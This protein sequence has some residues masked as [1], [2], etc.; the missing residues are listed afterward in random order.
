MQNHTKELNGKV[1]GVALLR[2]RGQCQV[3]D[4]LR[5]H[6]VAQRDYWMAT[7]FAELPLMALEMVDSF[8]L[9]F[10]MAVRAHSRQALPR[11]HGQHKHYLK[12]L[13]LQISYF[14]QG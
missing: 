14:L 3:T 4:L 6:E 7:P 13:Y 8:A 2:A 12:L 11:S 10:P 1:V 5:P 9:D